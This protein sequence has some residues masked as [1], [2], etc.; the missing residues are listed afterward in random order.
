M[1]LFICLTVL[2][3][4][5][6]GNLLNKSENKNSVVLFIG[7][8]GNAK[9][10]YFMKKYIENKG[11]V[12]FWGS[13]YF[14]ITK[15][16]KTIKR[17]L[18]VK[19][20]SNNLP[21]KHFDC[22]Y[23]ANV[24]MSLVHHILSQVSYERMRTF[25]DGIF[26][27]LERKR[28]SHLRKPSLYKKLTHY[29]QGRHIHEY[30]VVR[31]SELHYTVFKDM[32]NII[33]N[34]EYIQLITIPE[35]FKKI[36]EIS[37]FLGTVYSDV[38]TNKAL[39]MSELETFIERYKIDYYL[40]H[41]RDLERYFSNVEFIETEQSAEN[42]VLNYLESGYFVNLYGFFSSAQCLLSSVDMVKNYTLQFSNMKEHY[43][44]NDVNLAQKLFKFTSLNISK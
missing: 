29:I 16:F 33:E 5:I 25:D 44:F 2:H 28:L 19:K 18:Y 27:L 11:I 3:L 23:V 1:Q 26:N 42:V 15:P 31:Q 39:L 41:P 32:K 17:T 14:N 12:Y 13:E 36:R 9:N 34:T 37:I 7:E 10:Q 40:P 22:V 20:M 8:Q 38:S 30:D 4:R 35:T 24:D 43:E 6:V 21:I